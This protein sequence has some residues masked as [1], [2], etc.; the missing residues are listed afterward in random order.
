MKPGQ[1]ATVECIGSTVSAWLSPRGDWHYTGECGHF[2]AAKAIIEALGLEYI[3]D[4]DNPIDMLEALGWV[5]ISYGE[6][7]FTARRLSGSCEGAI[8]EAVSYIVRA[9]MITRYQQNFVRS[10]AYVV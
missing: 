6:I 4:M 10:A 3:E 9:G 7:I 1:V 8:T 5:H 2:D